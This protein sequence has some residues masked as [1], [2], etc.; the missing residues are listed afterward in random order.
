[1]EDIKNEFDNLNIELKKEEIENNLPNFLKIEFKPVEIA[2]PIINKRNKWVTWGE[3]NSFFTTLID[4]RN[5][6]PIHNS[7]VRYKGNLYAGESWRISNEEECSASEI[8][9]TN[10]FLSKINSKNESLIDVLQK[11]G[12]DASLT[13][14]AYLQPIW[15]RAKNKIVEIH[16]LH[17]NC[18]APE[19]IDENG[20]IN[21]YYFSTDFSNRKVEPIAIPTFNKDNA[22]GRQIIHFK[23]NETTGNLYFGEPDFVC[24]LQL[25]ELQEEI[26]N[27]WL[28]Y[29]RNGCFASLVITMP[30]G[31][32]SD[33]IKR[34]IEDNFKK[35][36]TGA[37]R[38]HL[39]LNFANSS[40]SAP[41][42]SHLTNTADLDKAFTVVQQIVNE[43][44]CTAHKITNQRL[45]GI[46]AGAAQLGQKDELLES[47]QIL[48][49][50]TIYPV[51]LKIE[52]IINTILEIN[53]WK[54]KIELVDSTPIE[55]MYSEPTLLSILSKNE[56][57]QRINFPLIEELPPNPAQQLGVG[58]LQSVTTILESIGLTNEQK[59]ALLIN[60]FGIEREKAKE[61]ITG[62]P[63][64]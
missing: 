1:M 44:I 2:K 52:R 39:Y 62:I 18:L 48:M 17:S 27:F 56:L 40:D 57:R 25:I 47:F 10:E 46:M 19:Q 26:A 15:N 64:I 37:D 50:T 61:I 16:H 55:F 58:G 30:S 32:P 43:S 31:I 12:L 14:N 59:L 38:K 22:G 24:A 34:Q 21:Y 60:L 7:A 29:I 36:Y 6:A 20:N 51:Q 49:N 3:S 54:T 9:Q 45:F 4:S 63:L 41:I 33:K 53:G 23:L 42:I 11:F 35:L 13:G 8:K 5:K 28:N